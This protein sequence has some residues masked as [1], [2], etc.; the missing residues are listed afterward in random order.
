MGVGRAGWDLRGI[1][2]AHRGRLL[3]ASAVHG[4]KS[5]LNQQLPAGLPWSNQMKNS[6]VPPCPVC[7]QHFSIF[8]IT[9]PKF[10]L[11]IT[12]LLVCLLA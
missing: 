6:S 11:K 12:Q 8:V 7:L 10:T 1:S 2:G 3:A 5:G 4:S 9:S